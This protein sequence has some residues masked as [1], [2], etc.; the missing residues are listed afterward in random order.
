MIPLRTA[1]E[2]KGFKTK[3]VKNN[4]FFKSKEMMASCA[5]YSEVFMKARWNY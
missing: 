5:Y 1:K 2:S 4:L 3:L